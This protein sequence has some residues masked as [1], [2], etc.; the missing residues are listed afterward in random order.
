MKEIQTY[1]S[2]SAAEYMRKE[3]READ[4]KEVFFCG[5]TDENSVINNV[6]VLARGNEFSVPAVIDFLSPENIVIHNHP[7]GALEPSFDDINIASYLGNRGIGVYIVNNEVSDIYVVVEKYQEEKKNLLEKEKL[8]KI[9]QSGGEVSKKLKNYELRK[10]Q[11]QMMEDIINGF[12]KNKIRII[13]AGTGIGKTLAYLIPAIYWSL[14]NKEICIVSTNT[15][16]LQEQIINKDIP[17]LQEVLDVEFKASLIKGRNNYIC[18]RK[19]ET[20]E[21]E[22]PALFLEGKEELKLIIDWA[23]QTADGDKSGLTF[24]P[25]PETWE[26]VCCEADTCIKMKCRYF[27][28]CFLLKAR[29][30]AAA[31]NLLIINHHL[32]FADLYIRSK[33]GQFS[34]IAVLP[35]YSR[36]IIDE[37]HHTEEVAT[38]YFRLEVSRGGIIRTLGRIYSVRKTGESKGLLSILRTKLIVKN[39][40]RIKTEISP[41]ILNIEEVLIP[42]KNELTSQAED[43]FKSISMLAHNIDDNS[44]ENK[45][46]R[47]K[48]NIKNSKLWKEKIIPEIFDFQKNL[49]SFSKNLKNLKESIKSLPYEVYKE[50]EDRLIELNSKIG[51]IKELIERLQEIF[52]T[53]KSDRVKWIETEKLTYY[54]RIAVISAPLNISS[55]LVPVLFEHFKTIVLTSATL[56]VNRKFDFFKKRIGLSEISHDKYSESIISSSFDYQTQ[57]IVGIPNDLPLPKDRDFNVNI[58][59]LIYRSV[60][61]SKGRAFILFTSYKLLNDSY[62]K[63]EESLLKNLNITALKQGNSSRSY[64]IDN[65]RR[66]I[67]SVLFGTDSFWE[68][69]DVEGSSLE[70]IIIVKLPFRVPSDPI[71]E[72]VTEDI[73]KKGGNSFNE[74]SLPLAVIKFKQG[75]GRL[76]RRKTDHGFILILDK[77]IIE[78]Y[79]GKIFLNSLPKCRIVSG[80]SDDIFCELNEFYSS[81]K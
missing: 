55:E 35:P 75:F 74:Y 65:F 32:L 5:Y 63:L 34:D 29:R 31:S 22:I 76:I 80:T 15:I 53:D 71:I 14:E 40:G 78:K 73:E 59:K 72:A 56:A 9:L 49:K 6:N 51:R 10:G 13:E 18:L 69:V 50:F 37:A 23:R 48:E 42:Q 21:R 19:V 79:Y 58:N 26:K 62:Q 68:G 77:R 41:I 27:E 43:I 67:S 1:I 47:I 61:L 12:N 81:F 33:S 30:K 45:K 7:S 46:L 2:D 17:F 8:L 44:F 20:E 38:N 54:E 16:N 36:I 39:K 66:D 24:I 28:N 3:I 64:L 57:V 60:S 11:L 25:A 52:H 70:S 4:G